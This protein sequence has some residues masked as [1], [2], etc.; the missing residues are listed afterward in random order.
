M[1]ICVCVSIKNVEKEIIKMT[2]YRDEEREG[3][4]LQEKRRERVFT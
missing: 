3:I 4:R 1:F 2:T